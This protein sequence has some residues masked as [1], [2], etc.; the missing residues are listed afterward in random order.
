[1]AAAHNNIAGVYRLQGRTEEALVLW[2][3]LRFLKERIEE[4]RRHRFSGSR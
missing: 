1:V 3:A 4:S 2:I